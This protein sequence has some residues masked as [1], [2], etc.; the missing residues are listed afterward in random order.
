MS[1]QLLIT[2]GRGPRECHLVVA[3]LAEI[4][5]AEA[6]AAG[7]TVSVASPAPD[8]VN[9][10]ASILLIVTGAAAT[11]WAIAVVGPVQWVAPSPW[12]PA[13][14]RRNWFV[15]VSLCGDGGPTDDVVPFDDR[16]V[17]FQPVRS[18]GPGGQRRNKVATAVRARHLPSGRT[19]VASGERTL[20]ANRAAALARL[21]E[22]ATR[23]QVEREQRRAGEQR[24]R[25]DRVTRGD[26]VRTIRAPLDGLSARRLSAPRP[27]RRPTS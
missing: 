17:T 18:G 16:D 19:V 3:R 2:A 14:A 22:L 13:H 5:I 6:T 27:R 10:R 24:N 1:A 25:H 9:G 26:P 11:Q 21:A 15:E 12:R 8:W 7:L 4:L 20:S 23:E